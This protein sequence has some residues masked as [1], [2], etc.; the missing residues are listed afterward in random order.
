MVGR[1]RGFISHMK[2]VVP[3]LFAIHCVVH[4]EHLVAKHLSVRLHDSLNVVITVVNKIK[5]SVLNDRIFRQ[6]CHENDTELNVF[7]FIVKLDGSRKQIVSVDV[8]IFLI[9]LLNFWR[10]R[11]PN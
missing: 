7:F 8:I 1:H 9:L 6:L 2:S 10:K 3:E 5:S 11:T 4:R